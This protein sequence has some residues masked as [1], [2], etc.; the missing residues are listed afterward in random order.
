MVFAKVTHARR[1]MMGLTGMALNFGGMIFLPMTTI[2]D[3]PDIGKLPL[4]AVY[5]KAGIEGL[6]R[7]LAM[8]LGP[9]GITVN[10]VAPGFVLTEGTREKFVGDATAL[11][12]S[13]SA[14]QAIPRLG[15]PEEIA[16]AVAFLCSD[17]AGTITG[18]TWM[19]DGGWH[20]L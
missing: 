20:R 9:H 7:G 11:A 2:L 18:Q 19:V 14:K 8:E 10:A 13:I 15:S 1:A 16:A 12:A 4:S 5:D 3:L 6:T 17:D